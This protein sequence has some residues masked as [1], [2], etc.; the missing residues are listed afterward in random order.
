MFGSFLPGLGWFAPP[1]SIRAWEPTLLWNQL[2][3]LTGGWSYRK[4]TNAPLL[5]P[6]VGPWLVRTTK[7]YPGVGA[8]IV[9]ESITLT[10]GWMVIP[11]V[12]ERA[13]AGPSGIHQ[14]NRKY[15]GRRAGSIGPVT[16]TIFVLLPTVEALSQLWP[17]WTLA[18]LLCY[19][20]SP[21]CAG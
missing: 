16:L 12:Y 1:K 8:D 6:Q 2:H 9:M 13:S 19:R 11:Q 21:T 10:D 14:I 20:S 15:R 3:S 7:V 17:A 5:D 4:C 18:Q